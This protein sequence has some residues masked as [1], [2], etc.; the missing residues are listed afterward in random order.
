[1]T[2]LGDWDSTSYLVRC[3]QELTAHTPQ[4]L[5]YYCTWHNHDATVGSDALSDGTTPGASIIR[6][7]E[8]A[9]SCLRFTG[10]NGHQ[11]RR[12]KEIRLQKY[13]GIDAEFAHC[14]D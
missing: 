10:H 12:A 3:P 4:I 14:D 7:I 8:N 1:V 2:D 6:Q 13:P 5:L 11:F 9:G